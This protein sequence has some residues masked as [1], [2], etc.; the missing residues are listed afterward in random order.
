MEQ[1][2]SK[3][4]LDVMSACLP[5]NAQYDKSLFKASAVALAL[6]TS[7]VTMQCCSAHAATFDCGDLVI[8]VVHTTTAQ[9]GV[10]YGS[11]YDLGLGAVCEITSTTVYDENGDEVPAQISGPMLDDMTLAI[12]KWME[13]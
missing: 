11:P 8:E 1:Q 10:Y 5:T 13:K 7:G 2:I 6:I 9:A 4:K 3:S 12:E